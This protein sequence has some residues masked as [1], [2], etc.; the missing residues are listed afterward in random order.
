MPTP[1]HVIAGPAGSGKTDR[2]L[3]AYCSSDSDSVIG[4]RLWIAPTHRAAQDVR[5]RVLGP[6][7]SAFLEPRVLTFEQLASQILAK[8]D[9][10]VRPI[11]R[12]VQR[13]ILTQLINEVLEQKKLN[14]FRTI[15]E[16]GGLV[17]LV[18]N[19]TVDL[20]RL[21]IWPDQFEAACKKRGYQSRDQELV[22][23]YRSYQSHLGENGLYDPEGRVWSARTELQQNGPKLLGDLQFV[24]ADGFGDFTRTQHEILQ[25]LADTERFPNVQL[26]VSL[27]LEANTS[28]NHLFHKS[29]GTFNRLAKYHT[30]VSV[31]FLDRSTT[32]LWPAL[33]HVERNLFANPTDQ[34]PVEQAE[35]IEIVA[36]E[37]E[38]GELE[39]VGRRIK[40]L[41]LDSDR[42]GTVH[43]QQIAV[44]MRSVTSAEPLVREVFGRLGIPFAIESPRRLGDAPVLS[45]LLS[46]LRLSTEDWPFRTLLGVINNNYIRFGADDSQ[47]A[48]TERIIRHLQIPKGRRQLFAQIERLVARG[49]NSEATDSDESRL[50]D[51]IRWS[52]DAQPILSELADALDQLPDQAS[53]SEWY[54]HIETLARRLGM[55]AEIENSIAD[56]DRAAW[57]RLGELLAA[58]EKADRWVNDK[59]TQFT[60]RELIHTISDLC[61]HEPLGTTLD[62][63]GCVR[64]LSAP[65]VRGLH[66]DYLFVVDLSEKSFPA[67]GQPESLYSEDEYRQLRRGGLPVVDHTERSRDEMLLFYEVITRAARKLWLTYAALDE[68]GQPLCP[69]PYVVEFER[70]CGEGRLAHVSEVRISPIPEGARP[71]SDRE[72]RLMAT[73]RALANDEPSVH[74]LVE[75]GRQASLTATHHNLL[76]GLNVVAE[77][78]SGERFGVFEGV[79]NDADIAGL[80]QQ[81]FGPDKLWSATQFEE[82]G[83]CPYRFFM[84][85]VLAVEEPEDISLDIDY[86]A[87]GR[88]LHETLTKAHRYLNER[89][90]RPQSP[91]EL[92]ESSLTLLQSEMLEMLRNT[93]ADLPA[94][95]DV[96]RA[97]LE[98]NRREIEQWILE[99]FKQHTE[100]DKSWEGTFEQPPRPAHFEVAYGLKPRPGDDESLSTQSPHEITLAGEKLRIGGRV[101]RI[102]VGQLAGRA[103]FNIIDYKSAKRRPGTSAEVDGTS[104][105]LDLYA[106]ATEEL[107]LADEHAMPWRAGYWMVRERGFGRPL[108]IG[109]LGDD[110][111]RPTEEW[112][113]RRAA[114]IERLTNMVRGIRDGQFPMFS[115]DDD[116]TGRCPY[117]TVCRVNQTRNLEKQWQV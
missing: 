96:D 81:R 94:G 69:S 98:V 86:G 76:A 24:V 48:N 30:D 90:G 62:E 83:L 103:V 105:Q 20:K 15:A 115:A 22:E 29:Q 33:A 100:Y 79:L 64:V 23:L 71:L 38:L 66:F 19:W 55:L 56:I 99:Y 74:L 107:L 82:Y 51:L 61:Q 21:E 63:T 97:L 27:P 39:A 101:D 117:R 106:M 65:S 80:L 34:S 91:S 50:N 4:K 45:S 28:R 42:G 35:G 110:G 93:I 72:W 73:S 88:A 44:V 25:A 49:I 17:D 14:Y 31:E 60:L 116:C 78:Q 40:G 41:L 7:R 113:S 52:N 47:R 112:L 87:R 68:S 46:I 8:S 9:D 10:F 104:L 53:S 32:R 67:L 109:E 16:R 1:I 2:L 5:S 6:G 43:P 54:A 11:D 18:T 26:H 77:R 58:V 59:T 70:A 108:E 37:S 95:S 3:S 12:L 57:L 92:D 89:A 85:Q 13:R 114:I 111:L 102:D 75:H 36:A 84:N